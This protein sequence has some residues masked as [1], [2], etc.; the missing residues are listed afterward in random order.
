MHFLFPGI[1]W[2]LGLLCIPIIIHLFYFRRYKKVYFTNVHLLQELVEETSTRNKLRDLLILVCRLLALLALI[3]AFAQPS[4][5]ENHTGQSLKSLS[6]FI[7]NSWSMEAES[8]EGKLIQQAIQLGKELVD[9][10]GENDRF[11][12]LSN[13]FE[14]KHQRVVTK[15]D[16]KIFLEEIKSSPNV[17]NLTKIIAR[18]IQCFKN[19]GIQSADLYIISDFQKNICAFDTSVLEEG[20]K[21]IL[22]PV[23]SVYENNISIDSAYFLAPVFLP[24]I[25]NKIVFQ[26]SNR[27][28]NKVEELRTSLNLNGQD[29]PGPTL[30]LE[31]S[32]QK[33]DTF[34]V[35]ILKPGWQKITIGIKDY[36][37]Q[38]DDHYYM[39]CVSDTNYKI[40]TI[41]QDPFPLSLQNAI[42][43]IPYFEFQ[44]VHEQRIQFNSFGNQKLIIL[45]GLKQVSSGLAQELNKAMKEGVQLFIF[46]SEQIAENAYQT[47]HDILNL[48]NIS[49][50][51]QNV[52]R[53]SKINTESNVYRDVFTR[54]TSQIKLPETKG[55]Y[56][57]IGGLPADKILLYRDGASYLNRYKVQN[58]Y[59]YYCASPFDPN[60]NDLS[61][62]AEIFIPL[63]FKVALNEDLRQIYSYDLGQEPMVSWPF[64]TNGN[65]QD[66]TFV[67]AGPEELIPSSRIQGNKILLEFYDQVKKSGI[68]ELRNKSSFL[69]CIAFNDSRVESNLSVYTPDELEVS[70]GNIATVL[71]PGNQGSFYNQIKSVQAGYNLW[72][73][74]IL[75]AALFVCMESFVLRFW[76]SA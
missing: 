47:L 4:L 58:A 44:A 64:E 13:N 2:A 15:A 51:T 36:P 9:A 68:Y 22:V 19:A 6:I 76:K 10:H 33:S 1:L 74:M 40:L 11:Q 24:G 16:A 29:Y 17:Q 34:S 42:Q 60:I 75:A 73:W 49:Q 61:K 41:Y 50:Y 14:G 26:V 18:Q 7:D 37:V 12:I 32:E 8:N 59:A 46:P 30:T 54:V 25:Q 31:A 56:Q 67:L 72:W 69:G 28:Q 63:L 35:N 66:L 5:K 43:S 21:L 27:G 57:F 3:L 62:N 38:F 52:Q 39:T 20:F 71:R 70:F 48:P 53:V 45:C 55:N 23:Q 65:Q